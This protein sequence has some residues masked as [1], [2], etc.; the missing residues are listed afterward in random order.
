MKVPEGVTIFAATPECPEFLEA[1]KQYIRDN[2]L[3]SDDVG[4]FRNN[5]T[6]CVITKKEI[7]IIV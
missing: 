1:A 7:E 6:L 3:T 2:K 5:S 4:I